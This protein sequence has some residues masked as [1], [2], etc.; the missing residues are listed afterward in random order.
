MKKRK[1]GVKVLIGI[2][3]VLLLLIPFTG[4]TA[5]KAEKETIVFGEG[6]WDSCQ[7]HSRIAAFILE[8]GYGYQSEFVPGDT[9]PLFAGLASGDL[10]V[11]MEIWV[12]NQQEAYD[13][14]IAAGQ[15]VDLG[16]NFPDSWQGWLV[17]TYVVKG[18]PARGIEPMAPDLKTIDDLPKYWELFKDPEVPTKGRFYNG[19]PGWE[20]TGHNT[21]K[22]ETYGLDGYFTNFLPGS[23]AAM[24]ASMVA[25]Y[26]KGEPW[27]GYYWA[28]TWVLG[29]LDMT[30]IEEPP[31]DQEIWE[32]TRGCNFPTNKVNIAVNSSLPDRAPEV[33]EFLRKYE[34][35]TAMVNEMLSYMQENKASTG[36]A[37]IYFLQEYESLWTSWVPSDVASKV[38]AALP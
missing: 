15:V 20:S 31:F 21:Q 27:F 16:S 8:N 7:L 32:T 9:I 23:D 11:E 34:T 24:S 5:G 38:K 19:V 29:E 36:E 10:D 35:T 1:P 18:D 14:A 13:K 37:A 25:A 22:L 12:E 28:P 4:C 26:E 2:L 17:P 3:G 30:R 33:V 6:N